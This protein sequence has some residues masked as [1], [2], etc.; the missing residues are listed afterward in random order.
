MVRNLASLPGPP[1]GARNNQREFIM[2]NRKTIE[3]V[4]EMCHSVIAA[5]DDALRRLDL[6][7][8]HRNKYDRDGTI[9]D[10]SAGDYSYGSRETGALRRRSM[11]LTRLLAELR[12][13]R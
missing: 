8:E 3:E 4:K 5:C 1:T 12:R 10:A 6:E 7:V 9:R 11:D 2:M 13:H